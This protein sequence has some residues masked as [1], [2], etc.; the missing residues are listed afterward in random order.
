MEITPIVQGETTLVPVERPDGR[1]L[2][3]YSLTADGRVQWH[4]AV[5]VNRIV[6]GGQLAVVAV[7]AVSLLG[8]AVIKWVLV[9]GR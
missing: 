2:G 6:A 4:P 9:R 8:S 7:V 1:P 5:D 3:A